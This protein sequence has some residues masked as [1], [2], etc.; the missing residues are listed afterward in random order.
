MD[1]GEFGKTLSRLRERAELSNRQLADRA[2]VPHSL[3]A[4]LQSVRRRVGEMQAL[5]IGN[6]LGL[7]AGELDGFVLAAVNTCTEKVLKSSLDYP[8]SFLNLIA[9]QLRVAG[10]LP[11]HFSN[12]QINGDG[13]GQEVKLYLNDGRIAQLS[14]TLHFA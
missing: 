10:I 9:K 6:A 7:T 2:D 8:S 1:N 11:Q 4:G 12:F 5:R 14:S 13:S 3:I